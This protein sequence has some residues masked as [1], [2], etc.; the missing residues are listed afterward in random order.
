MEP[1][2]LFVVEPTGQPAAQFLH[3]TGLQ[4]SAFH[5]RS[6]YFLGLGVEALSP[7]LRAY[8]RHCAPE[9]PSQPATWRRGLILG[10]PR[11]G[12]VLYRSC[13]LAQL[14]RGLPDCEWYYLCEPA[15][16]EVLVGNPSLGGIL[17]LMSSADPLDLSA[18]AM[19]HLQSLN[20]DVALCTEKFD[21][22]RFLLCALKLR[23]PNRVCYTIKGFSAWVTHPVPISYPQPLAAYFRDYVAHITGQAPDWSLK[24]VIHVDDEDRRQAAMVWDEF[25]LPEDRPVLVVFAT[26]RER[27]GV[28]PLNHA[29]RFIDLVRAA[30][31]AEVVA[32]GAHSDVGALQELSAL[33]GRPVPS[34]AGRLGLRALACFLERCAAVVCPDSGPRHVANAVG[35][36]V[37]FIS[38]PGS[39][40]VETGRYCNNEHDLAPPG[41]LLPRETHAR[42]F[43]S[44]APESV[45]DAVAATLDCWKDQVRRVP[46]F[47]REG[48][49]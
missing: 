32:C 43:E 20:F 19:R 12:D 25:A 1:D 22:W 31:R 14:Q 47:V 37:F 18:A 16:A 6:N 48:I 26:S 23:I 8:A 13:S 30:G 38:N 11:I 21:Y 7:L 39:L 40:R 15:S 27:S 46:T 29:A 49:A 35:V 9:P 5:T 41:Q 10:F 2:P 36:S 17:P 44:I 4:A 24:P 28:W 42:W 34:L 33:C 45:F 3:K